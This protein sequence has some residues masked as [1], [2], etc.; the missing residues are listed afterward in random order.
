M[1]CC[2]PQISC[3]QGTPPYPVSCTTLQFLQFQPSMLIILTRTQLVLLPIS[4]VRG[5]V[6]CLP[7]LCLLQGLEPPAKP[8]EKPA[9]KAA[10][11]RAKPSTKSAAKPAAQVAATTHPHPP[12]GSRIRRMCRLFCRIVGFL[13]PAELFY[14]F[15]GFS[16]FCPTTDSLFAPLACLCKWV[17]CI[18]GNTFLYVLRRILRFPQF[19]VV[20]AKL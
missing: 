20:P 2:V 4:N 15:V 1:H 16:E 18:Q 5:A 13:D 14:L 7:R 19:Q 3:I 17:C 9:P 6:L 12:F 10:K 8:S 11:P